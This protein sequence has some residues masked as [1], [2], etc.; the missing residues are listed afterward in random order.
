MTNLV[1][2]A[3]PL[4]NGWGGRPTH[5]LREKPWGQGCRLTWDL[6]AGIVLDHQA[7]YE[8]FLNEIG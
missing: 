2:R 4:K 6:Q 7:N 1:P 8:S 5:I 3:F